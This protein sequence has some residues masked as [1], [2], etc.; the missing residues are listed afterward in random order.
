MSPVA[1]KMGKKSRLDHCEQPYQQEALSTD[2]PSLSVLGEGR[3]L[4]GG[5]GICRRLAASQMT[6][7]GGRECR[8]SGFSLQVAS[9]KFGDSL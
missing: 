4:L 6:E 5:P 1:E 8:L 9:H 3:V 2:S 7:C